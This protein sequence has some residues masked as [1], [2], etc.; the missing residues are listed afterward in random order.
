MKVT[1]L[2]ADAAQAVNGKLYILGGGWSVAGPDPTPMAIALKIEVPWDEAN[3][4]HEFILE[5]LNADDQPV[6]VP[7]PDGDR[8]IELRGNFEVG[9]PAGLVV[10]TPLDTTLA[11][12][13]GPLPI[14]PGGRYVWRLSIDGRADEN[15]ELAFST[16]TGQPDRHP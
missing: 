2:L 12:N 3:R 1:M 15:W 9:R 6:R 4:L 13:I 7:T 14:P 11:I 10:G 5:L 16:R 8:P